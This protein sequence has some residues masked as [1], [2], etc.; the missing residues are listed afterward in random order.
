MPDDVSSRILAAATLA[1]DA[2]M[3]VQVMSNLRNWTELRNTR[4]EPYLYQSQ[5]QLIAASGPS[6]WEAV[7]ELLRGAVRL[8]SEHPDMPNSGERSRTLQLLLPLAD[9]IIRDLGDQTE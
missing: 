3:G 7:A 2:S 8:H 1:E 5:L 6:H 9:Q 4:F